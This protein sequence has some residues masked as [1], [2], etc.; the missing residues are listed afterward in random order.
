MKTGK[1]L[2]E[3]AT[4]IQRQA[5]AKRDFIVPTE[6]LEMRHLEN[7]H[8]LGFGDQEVG[9]NKLA[10][11][12]IAEHTGIPVKY[13]ERMRDEAPALL[14]DNVN[15][16]FRR[17]PAPRMVRTLDGNARA[18][19]SDK[20]RPLENS[21]LA[22]AVLPPLLNLG[23]EV[24]SCEITERR[25]YIKAVDQRIN[26][27]IP[28]GKRMGDGG[29]TIFD[30][31]CPA[32]VISNSEVGMGM[33]SVETS[34]FT[35]ACTN[36][37]TF[38]NR[39][40]RKYHTGARHELGEGIYGLLS[41]KTR[42]VT[43]AALW[44][45]VR[46]IV[47][48]AFEKAQFEAYA[49]EMAGMAEQPIKGDI[50]EVVNLTAKQFGVNDTEKKSILDHLIKG[51]DLTRYGLFNAITRTAEDLDSY[52]RATEFERLGGQIVELGKNEWERI[53]EAA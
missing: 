8:H 5:S 43:D 50:V 52:D 53:A 38:S 3:L 4:E 29:H 19:L 47:A 20:Y 46:D 13:Y 11:G 12:Q 22:E 6:R 42:K 39:S 48:N 21:D 41:D 49:N 33:L 31:V 17:Y 24:I 51:G 2:V 45:Q 9:V 37:A 1:T 40:V 23:V 10:H 32:I 26:K 18:F 14:S 16:W 36:L 28:S 44:M 15:E 35:R 34:I 25:C 27:D 7:G 30:T